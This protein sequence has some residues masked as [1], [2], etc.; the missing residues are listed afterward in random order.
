[1][2]GKP[3]A[4]LSAIVLSLACVGQQ[5]PDPIATLRHAK[6]QL[7]ADLERLPRYT[8]VQTI[9]RTYFDA[10]AGAHGSSCSSLIAAEA[11]EHQA[12][13]FGWDRLRVEVAW[14]DGRNL[15]SWLG[16]PAFGNDNLESL[17]NPG[18][19]ASGDFGVVL[20]EILLRASIEFQQEQALD[21]RHI[22]Q[23]SYDMPLEKSTY[24]I[25]TADGT[26]RL[27]YSGSLVFDAET[28]D[29]LNLTMR[30]SQLPLSSSTCEAINQ[31]SYG[32]TSIH[33]RLALIPRQVQLSTIDIS[34]TK[35]LNQATFADCREY[36]STIRLL[37]SANTTNPERAAPAAASPTPLP[38]G[39]GFEA[40]LVTPIESDT[41]AAGD[42]IEAVLRT[43]LHGK[44]KIPIAPAG[45]R[46][47]AD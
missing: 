40:R 20:R 46:I 10:R 7:L 38:A 15:Y 34:G 5:Q 13:A 12:P 22:L 17:A 36:K 6:E 35:S 23:Y 4:F 14:I 24:S 9:T 47:K 44:N 37:N 19:F 21:G 31:V 32:R 43:P 1:M 16:E 41:A 28:S 42:P 3:V 45:S 26:A 27:A 2:N 39:I 29:L 33:D 8:C 25:K 11:R 30:I 18:P